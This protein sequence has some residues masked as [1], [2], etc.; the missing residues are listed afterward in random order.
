[1]LCPVTVEPV[2]TQVSPLGD[3]VPLPLI[4]DQT[5]GPTTPPTRSAVRVIVAGEVVPLVPKNEVALAVILTP[6]SASARPVTS[7]MVIGTG[8]SLVAAA[9]SST[10]LAFTTAAIIRVPPHLHGLQSSQIEDL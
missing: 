5:T 10:S 7:P 3:T 2:T 6:L 4:T 1:M 8:S 9:C